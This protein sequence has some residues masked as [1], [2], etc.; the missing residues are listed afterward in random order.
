MHTMSRLG[1]SPYAAFHAAALVS[2]A[3]LAP[4]PTQAP[5]YTL[6]QALRSTFTWVAQHAPLRV[7]HLPQLPAH[8]AMWPDVGNPT[9]LVAALDAALVDD[10]QLGG[11]GRELEAATQGHLSRQ[12]LAAL[13]PRI[14]RGLAELHLDLVDLWAVAEAVYAAQW[15]HRFEAVMPEPQAAAPA[16][17]SAAGGAAEPR[18]RRRQ[19]RAVPPNFRYDMPPG[20]TRA[21]PGQLPRLLVPLVFHVMSSSSEPAGVSKSPEYVDR[22]V[23]LANV[24]AQPTN[25]QFFVQVGQ[26]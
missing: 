16:A 19:L 14:G 13:V 4:H 23:R 24:M 12:A 20:F 3:S 11:V 10:T 18:V 26:E 5:R 2:S 17:P 15:K 8:D 25:V 9:D 1:C 22:W 7:Q 6:Y 21:P